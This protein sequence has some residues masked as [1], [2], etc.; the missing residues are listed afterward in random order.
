MACREAGVRNLKKQ[1]E[2]V[3]RKAARTLVERGV[4]PPPP[5]TEVVSDTTQPA[6]SSPS[7]PPAPSPSSSTS[8]SP[9]DSPPESPHTPR[10][11][12]EPASSSAPESLFSEHSASSSLQDHAH[13]GS[14]QQPSTSSSS[15]SFAQGLWQGLRDAMAAGSSSAGSDSASTSSSL[16]SDSSQSR[17]ESSAG[18]S[19]SG[20][21]PPQAPARDF[22]DPIIVREEDLHSYVGPPPFTSDKIYAD[23]T[24]PG[25]VMG[26]AWT[27]MG[28]NSLYVEAASISRSEGKG[29]IRCTGEP[30]DCPFG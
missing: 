1:L 28:G 13:S 26:L 30:S 3:F 8:D 19:S 17:A 16:Q 7:T 18:A 21:Q 29:S 2:K 27:A 4:G 22:G 12:G 9:L 25:V 6:A 20:A 14:S 10:Q 11:G 5:Q 15:P 23:A 24:P